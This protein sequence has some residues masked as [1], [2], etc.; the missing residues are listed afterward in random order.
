MDKNLSTFRARE[1]FPRSFLQLVKSSQSKGFAELF[2]VIIFV[3]WSAR[4]H[5]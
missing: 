4:P 2:A 5:S 1:K 3:R